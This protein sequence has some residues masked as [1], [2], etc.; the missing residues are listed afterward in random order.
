MRSAAAA[1]ARGAGASSIHQNTAHHLRGHGE[2]VGA[3]LPAD[4]CGIDHRRDQE[5]ANYTAYGSFVRSPA[6]RPKTEQ[7]AYEYYDVK[8]NIERLQLGK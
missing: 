2:E 3:V 5:G 4:A 8:G 1:F 7:I 6:W